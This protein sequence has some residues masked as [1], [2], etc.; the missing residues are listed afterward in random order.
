MYCGWMAAWS[1]Q[2]QGKQNSAVELC[3]RCWLLQR[4][5][6]SGVL[7]RFCSLFSVREL[8]VCFL[9]KRSAESNPQDRV[10][11]S[12]VDRAGFC[13]LPG[14]P[15]SAESVTSRSSSVTCSARRSSPARGQAWLGSGD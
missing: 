9:V 10:L 5:M 14:R 3:G 4:A 8:T 2:G 11:L 12:L 6:M 7:I 1:L 13:W 15:W